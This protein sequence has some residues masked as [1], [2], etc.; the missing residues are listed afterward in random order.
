MTVMLADTITQKCMRQQIQDAATWMGD[1]AGVRVSFADYVIEEGE[2][3]TLQR[4]Q[5]LVLPSDK[6]RSEN[7][8]ATTVPSLQTGAWLGAAWVEYRSDATCGKRWSTVLKHEFGHVYG[9]YDTADDRDAL[10]HWYG[11]GGDRLRPWE[12]A[13]IRRRIVSE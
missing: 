5:V 10:M 9:L 3:L 13:H 2:L 1:R 12:L 7:A 6:L 4:G 8:L 11:T